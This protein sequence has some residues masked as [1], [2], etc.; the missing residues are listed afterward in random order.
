MS[1]HRLQK[2]KGGKK[3]K[4]EV[5][6]DTFQKLNDD[7]KNDLVSQEIELVQAEIEGVS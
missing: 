7:E 1:F 2:K 4:A 3:T 6:K 5:K